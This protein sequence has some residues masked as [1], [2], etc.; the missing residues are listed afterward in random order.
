MILFLSSMCW[1]LRKHKYAFASYIILQYFVIQIFMIHP[2]NVTNVP[3]KNLKSISC[4]LLVWWSREPKHQHLWYWH[5]FPI[6]SWMLLHDKG[7]KL[8]DMP[9][10]LIRHCNCTKSAPING[11]V[12]L[13]HWLFGHIKGILP[14]GPYPPCLHMADRA[15][16]A[17]YHQHQLPDCCHCFYLRPVL[18][19]GNCC[20][21]CLYACPSICQSL[22]C[23]QDDSWPVQTRITK[24]GPKCKIPWLICWPI[25][26][27][28]HCQ[29]S[30]LPDHEF[31]VYLHDNA[32]PVQARITKFRP[33]VQNNFKIPI[34]LW[35]D[36]HTIS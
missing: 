28:L 33:K 20:C 22:A 17:G 3:V 27:D 6:I 19:F 26:L 35:G 36:C 21:L 25:D 5:W 7:Q 14:K 23:L 30:I 31:Q 8:M 9:L 1:I 18:A 24:F 29:I 12:S 2:Q 32:S 10:H 16:L 15:L 11:L 34:V 13:Q 4:L